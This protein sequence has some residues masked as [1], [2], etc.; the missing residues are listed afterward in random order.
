MLNDLISLCNILSI[1]LTL[2]W[3][4]Q[5]LACKLIELLTWRTLLL[6]GVWF[7]AK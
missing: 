1:A 6:I 3:M 5:W 7:C 4:C 2:V